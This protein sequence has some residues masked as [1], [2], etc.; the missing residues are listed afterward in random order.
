MEPTSRIP[1]IIRPAEPA[2]CSCIHGIEAVAAPFPWSYTAIGQELER[3]NPLNFIALAREGRFA[4]GYILGIIVAD[5]MCVH[6]LA[7]LPAF[8]RQGIGRRLLEHALRQARLR[9]A[10]RAY[11]EVRSK[12]AGAIALYERTGFA[13]Q[14]I[15]KKYYCADG[16]D[17]LILGKHPLG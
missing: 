10:A 14:S 5:E 4:C 13:V 9:G 17:A 3:T 6:N 11:L 16:D 7:V 2:D 15:R 1:I 12:N 8:R